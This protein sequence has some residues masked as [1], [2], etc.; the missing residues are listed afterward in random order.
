MGEHRE[1]KHESCSRTAAAYEP[2]HVGLLL[3]TVAQGREQGSRVAGLPT[4]EH[5][6][7]AADKPIEG[8]W[9]SQPMACDYAKL[10]EDALRFLQAATVGCVSVPHVAGT[11][12]M[13]GG[14]LL[15]RSDPG[16]EELA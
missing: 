9:N 8:V 11:N 14:V 10:P 16:L 5:L 7:S 1:D 2:A 4:L 13:G 12:E 6:V 3:D 15:R